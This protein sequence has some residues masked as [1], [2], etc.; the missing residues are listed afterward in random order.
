MLF[1]RNGYRLITLRGR[2]DGPF[3]IDVVVGV[4]FMLFFIVLNFKMFI[5]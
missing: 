2:K 5:F 4:R 3:L 1:G